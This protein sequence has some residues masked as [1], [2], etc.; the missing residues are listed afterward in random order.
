[1]KVTKDIG[2]TLKVFMFF[3]DKYSSSSSL[4]FL[5]E[6]RPSTYLYTIHNNNCSGKCL[7]NSITINI[8]ECEGYEIYKCD[9]KYV[10]VLP[11]Q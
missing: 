7:H 1:M 2:V 10:A 5:V 4:I 3:S 9:A 6:L 11:F 8:S